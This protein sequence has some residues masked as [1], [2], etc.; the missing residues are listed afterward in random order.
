MK[1]TATITLALAVVLLA[2]IANHGCEAAPS[3]SLERG[4]TCANLGEY[5][6]QNP[7]SPIVPCCAGQGV[8]YQNV[9]WDQWNE[10]K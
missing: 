7:I 10:C 9:I 1:P 5:C 8:C 4:A 2:G 3:E 6:N